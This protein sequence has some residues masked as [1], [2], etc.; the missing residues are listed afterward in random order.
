MERKDEVVERFRPTSGRI[1]GIVTMVCAG[2][3]VV[4]GVFEAGGG[5]PVWA[6]AAFFL[7]GVLAWTAMLRPALWATKDSLVMRGMASTT[8]VPLAAIESVVVRQVLAVRAGDQRHVS[9]VVGRA[10]RK[11]VTT[12]RKDAEKASRTADVDYASFVEDRVSG[13]ASNARDAAGIRLASKEQVALAATVRRSWDLEPIV[14]L[15]LG[16]GAVLIG[17]VL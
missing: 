10:W 3:G 2:A 12:S 5:F 6:T 17:L 13:L 4:L 9:P 16:A 7:T 11:M 1:M 14:A 8:V 15:C